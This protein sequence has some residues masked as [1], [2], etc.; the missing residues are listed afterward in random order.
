MNF[1]LPGLTN[2]M[3]SRSSLQIILGIK[4]AIYKY[5]SVGRHQVQTL[6]TYKRI[7]TLGALQRV[8]FWKKLNKPGIANNQAQAL[9]E[10]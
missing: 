3:S 8:Y 1:L 5:Y 6:S 7:K 4:I 10:E 2:T 9:T